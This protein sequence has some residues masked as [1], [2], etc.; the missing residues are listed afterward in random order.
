MSLLRNEAPTL[1]FVD[2]RQFWVQDTE[3]E[4]LDNNDDGVYGGF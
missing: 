1:G 2:A 4:A 3:V